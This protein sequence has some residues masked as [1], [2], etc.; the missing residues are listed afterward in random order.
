[1]DVLHKWVPVI[2][3]RIH[4]GGGKDRPLE[5]HA[6]NELL[7]SSGN[8]L[9]AITQRV[10]SSEFERIKVSNSKVLFVRGREF[11]SAKSLRQV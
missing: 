1:M 9:H 11:G 8:I 10:S 3:S 5:M 7:D 2:K 4:S 6:W